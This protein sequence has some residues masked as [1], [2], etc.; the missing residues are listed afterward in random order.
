MAAATCSAV[1]IDVGERNQAV[2]RM[3]SGPSFCSP[4]SKYLEMLTVERASVEGS[5]H[6]AATEEDIAPN[7]RAETTNRRSTQSP[8]CSTRARA[9]PAYRGASA[10]SVIRLQRLAEYGGL[11]S[12]L[13]RC[14][15]RIPR[16]FTGSKCAMGLLS[17]LRVRVVGSN[18]DMNG[19]AR[20]AAGWVDTPA[21]RL[22]AAKSSSHARRGIRTWLPRQRGLFVFPVPSVLASGTAV[23]RLVPMV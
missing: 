8:S 18:L 11:T 12:W 13:G 5:I 19:S 14:A 22:V 7:R 10:E 2:P 4:P 17:R 9:E 1:T 21:R 16:T 20:A 23:A 15:R 6:V 3:P